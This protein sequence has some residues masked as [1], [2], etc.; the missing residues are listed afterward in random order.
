M[1]IV[2]ALRE[3]RPDAWVVIQS[4]LPSQFAEASVVHS[5]NE[6]SR[7]LAD[8]TK[9][10][11]FYNSSDVFLM[12]L[13]GGGDGGVGGDIT[14]TSSTTTTATVNASRFVSDGIHPNEEG[15]RAQ[16]RSMVEFLRKLH[17]DRYYH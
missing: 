11:F 8:S 7:C 16:A 10:T 6:A 13:S 4:L 9:S 15:A 5:I 2:R 1:A 3:R 14:P 12:P 17:N